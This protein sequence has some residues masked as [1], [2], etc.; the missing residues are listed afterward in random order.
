MSL[1]VD[2]EACTNN[3][4]CLSS[5]LNEEKKEDL[6]T[7]T[8]APPSGRPK[9]FPMSTVSR[10]YDMDGKGFLDDTELA[11]RR[12]DSQNLGH[13]T[14]DKVYLIMASLQKEQKQSAELLGTMQRQ[15]RQMIQMKHGI[16]A[17][18][19]FSI[20]LALSNV[21]TSF[22]AARLAREVEVSQSNGDLLDLHSGQRVGVTPKLPNIEMQPLSPTRRRHLQTMELTLCNL[23][24]GEDN[25]TPSCTI[26]GTLSYSDMVS[27]HSQFCNSWDPRGLGDNGCTGG[28]VDKVRLTCNGRISDIYDHGL[29]QFGPI[30]DVNHP[31]YP[32]TETA[33]FPHPGRGYDGTQ[34][35]FPPQRLS[36]GRFSSQAAAC[37]QSFLVGMYCNMD[38][39]E[40]CI[41]LSVVAPGTGACFGNEYVQ[42]CGDPV[43]AGTA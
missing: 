11:L 39:S 28:G 23:M 13:L 25:E 6:V 27:L 43:I 30:V 10:N 17:L 20:L 19:V 35:I 22:A 37:T 16:F 24:L 32:E 21:G 33:V 40:E 7:P 41:V 2:I 12:L 34:F 3:E 29:D 26:A 14:N 38:D 5:E 1:S 4:D 36:R 42:L 15:Q 8:P 9:Y 18:A 31:T